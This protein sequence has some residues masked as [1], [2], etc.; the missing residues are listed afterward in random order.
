M[1]SEQAISIKRPEIDDRTTL[2]LI[3]LI[4]TR[5]NVLSL[6]TPQREYDLLSLPSA[7]LKSKA[8]PSP[9]PPQEGSTS[10]FEAITP[11]L[12]PFAPLRS[13]LFPLCSALPEEHLSHPLTLLPVLGASETLAE[14]IE[15][16]VTLIHVLLLLRS[17]VGS[18]YTSKTD[19]SGIERRLL[20]DIPSRHY[21]LRYRLISSR[22]F[23]PF[24][25][26]IC[27]TPTRNRSCRR[28]TT[29]HSTNVSQ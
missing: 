15:S 11:T 25:P 10:P 24:S 4:I 8:T 6:P 28:I 27:A 18:F 19:C 16:S 26:A 21:R 5:R 23:S 14:V 12:P 2:R 3:L 29:M 9:A 22:S 20:I 7:I 1:S 17:A 13:H